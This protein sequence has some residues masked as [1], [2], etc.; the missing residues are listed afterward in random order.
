MGAE[1]WVDLL[2]GR[3]RDAVGEHDVPAAA[4]AMA[5]RAQAVGRGRA[6]ASEAA[7]RAAGGRVASDRRLVAAGRL[8]RL[9]QRVVNVPSRCSSAFEIFCAAAS[10]LAGV[11]PGAWA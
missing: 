11:L 3:R 10:P 6:V 1:S 2:F 7:A 4:D 5:E 9:G 8:R